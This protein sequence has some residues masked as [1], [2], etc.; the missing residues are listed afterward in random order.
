M[1]L[2]QSSGSMAIATLSN[3]RL[4]QGITFYKPHPEIMRAYLNEFNRAEDLS[5][6]SLTP[7]ST[8]RRPWKPVEVPAQP[9]YNAPNIVVKGT[10][11][12]LIYKTVEAFYLKG[13]PRVAAAAQ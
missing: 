7:T 1:T 12:D 10:A 5:W 11:G 8:L 2:G 3:V 4:G 13:D 9:T 6:A